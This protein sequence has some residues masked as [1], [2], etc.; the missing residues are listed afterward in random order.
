[1]RTLLLVVDSL[2]ADAL[3]CYG[4]T[5]R[6]PT[7]DRL[8][9]DGARFE[10][11]VSSAPWTLPSL[12]AMLTGVWSHRLGL[13]KWEQPWPREA[14]TLFD[15]FRAEGVET[16]S[17]VFD[18]EHLFR[19]CPEAGVVGSSQDTD[20]MLAW[21]RERRRGDYFALVHY[22]WTHVP[23]LHQKLPLATWNAV[24]NHILERLSA[25]D[26]ALRHAN[27]EQVKG[28]YSLAVE[29]FSERWLPALLDAARADVLVLVADH[30]E[31]WGERLGPSQT[32]DDVFDL[33]GNHLH[34]EVIRVPLIVHAPSLVRPVVV[35]GL[36]RTV[37][38]M[39]TLVELLELDPPT[40]LAEQPAFAPS[41]RSLACALDSG[42]VADDALAFCSRNRDFVDSPRLPS[43]PGDVYV[44]LA[45]RDRTNK[46]IAEFSG[47]RA[48]HYDLTADP[49]ELH[50][51]DVASPASAPLARAL[52]EEKGTAVVAAHDPADFARMTRQ[53]RD[54]GYL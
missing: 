10:T 38:L 9:A 3:G 11:V 29:E 43:E 1:M 22:W 40:L 26:P 21:F 46:V 20:A 16:A 31:S 6:T 30:G 45:C 12:A 14:P 19:S 2:R 39:P 41:G 47:E 13:M 35:G 8:A 15:C 42:R 32:L 36:A 28:L 53:L 48:R 52:H 51:A 7:V 49:D 23:Y 5:L 34:D 37:D 50:P 44:E 4:S 27:R 17:F 24:C 25:P 33:H 54:L 18:P